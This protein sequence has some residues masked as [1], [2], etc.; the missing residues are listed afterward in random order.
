MYYYNNINF[1]KIIKPIFHIISNRV[2]IFITE[3]KLSF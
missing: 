1:M 2:L 3:T